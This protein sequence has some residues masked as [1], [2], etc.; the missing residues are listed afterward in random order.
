MCLISYRQTAVVL[1]YSTFQI[2]ECV[3]YFTETHS[4]ETVYKM[5]DYSQL[6]SGI[7]ETERKQ[8]HLKQR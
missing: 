5:L 6:V 4:Y 1:K 7:M 3:K 2:L 8:S